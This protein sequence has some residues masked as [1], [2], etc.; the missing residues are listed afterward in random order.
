M[1][2]KCTKWCN[3]TINGPNCKIAKVWLL[4]AYKLN[5]GILKLEYHLNWN[6]IMNYNGFGLVAPNPNAV[7]YLEYKLLIFFVRGSDRNKGNSIQFSVK[8]VKLE[9]PGNN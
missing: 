6:L 8:S 4:Y 7:E 3:F 5:Y 9:N 2:Q 1:V